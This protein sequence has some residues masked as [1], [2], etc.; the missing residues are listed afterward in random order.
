MSQAQQKPKKK[1]LSTAI[2]SFEPDDASSDWWIA[3]EFFFFKSTFLFLFK[4]TLTA[5]GSSWAKVQIRDGYS[6]SGSYAAA[7]SEA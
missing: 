2:N 4:A 6:N 5:Y 7:Y 3:L 1:L